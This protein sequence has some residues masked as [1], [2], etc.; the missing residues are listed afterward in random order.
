MSIELNQE[1]VELPLQTDTDYFEQ[2]PDSVELWSPGSPLFPDPGELTEGDADVSVGIEGIT[3]L[4][5]AR[6]GP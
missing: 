5:R 6:V 4:L 2:H 1:F 3:A